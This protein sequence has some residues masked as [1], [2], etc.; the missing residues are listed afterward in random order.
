MQAVADRQ[1]HRWPVMTRNELGLTAILWLLVVVCVGCM[2]YAVLFLVSAFHP[3]W[4]QCA[5]EVDGRIVE[6][7]CS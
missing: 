4:N 5:Y 1:I 7:D 6:T 2:L 3:A